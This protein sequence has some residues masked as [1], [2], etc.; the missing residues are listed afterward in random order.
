MSRRSVS[1]PISPLG[2]SLLLQIE[3]RRFKSITINMS[4][5]FPGRR[6]SDHFTRSSI[7]HPVYGFTLM[8]SQKWMCVGGVTT[9]NRFLSA[10]IN[11]FGLI[12]FL[13]CRSPFKK[14]VFESK[15][16]CYF[17]SHLSIP[18]PLGSAWTRHYCTYDKGSKT[19]TMS[20]TENKSAG[21]QVVQLSS[22]CFPWVVDEPD[23]REEKG[24]K[25]NRASVIC[26][27]ETKSLLVSPPREENRKLSKLLN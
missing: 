22:V 4:P 8:H 26:V 17:V 9:N 1:P 15:T 12:E 13:F 6:R 23:K 7:I 14:P 18:G 21:K 5:A 10:S 25:K 11:K 2:L 16:I 19:F 3:V 27:G 20:N 24:G